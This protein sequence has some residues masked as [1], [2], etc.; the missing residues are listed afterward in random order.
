MLGWNLVWRKQHE[1][2]I[3]ELER[4]VSLD[5]NSEWAYGFLAEV[6]NFAGRPDEA[7]GFAKKAMRLD[8]NYPAW[9]VFHLAESYFLLHRNEEA[10]SAIKDAL[11]R[12]PTFL[13]ARRVLAIIYAEQGRTGEAQ[14][15]VAEILRISPDAS[16]DLWRQR[17]VYKNPADLERY[18]AGLRKAGMK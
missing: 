13:P 4:A 9:I 15:E 11:H 8:P 5:P 10:V 17:M 12:N 6:L 1:T 18:I 14:R 16:L 3:S 2:A 7:I